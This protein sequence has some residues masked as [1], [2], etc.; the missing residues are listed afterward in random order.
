MLS[1]HPMSPDTS[2]TDSQADKPPGSEGNSVNERSL[3]DPIPVTVKARVFSNSRR[4]QLIGIINSASGRSLTLDEAIA[5]LA[6]CP[7]SHKTALPPL[8]TPAVDPANVDNGDGEDEQRGWGKPP[9]DVHRTLKISLVKTH[10]PMLD[11]LGVIDFG[12][13]FPDENTPAS[14][15]DDSTRLSAGPRF[16]E[17]ADSLL[18]LVDVC[19]DVSIR[20]INTRSEATN[21]GGRR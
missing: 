13:E 12:G 7:A 3:S 17:F 5:Q 9:E 14:E 6:S 19:E 15:V 2:S 20:D 11:R 8:P 18:V 10:L 21:G 1:T 16:R 4:L